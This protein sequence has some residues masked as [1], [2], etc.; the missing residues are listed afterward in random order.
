MMAVCFLVRKVS[1]QWAGNFRERKTPRYVHGR[2]TC[3]PRVSINS[4][5]PKFMSQEAEQ[6]NNQML[7]SCPV[8][9]TMH[10]LLDPVPSHKTCFWG[11][12]LRTVTYQWNPLFQMCL[13]DI[14]FLHVS[15]V[16]FAT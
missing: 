15:K 3:G 14:F 7:C 2:H 12:F 10:P 9:Q 6:E 13:Q 11:E 1:S 4:H 5:P 8:F 16:R